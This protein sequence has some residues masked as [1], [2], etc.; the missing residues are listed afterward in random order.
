MRGCDDTVEI[1]AGH[2]DLD[3]SLVADDGGYAVKVLSEQNALR[4]VAN[5]KSVPT[6]AAP[7]TA[8]TPT[9]AK[10][11]AAEAAHVPE[12]VAMLR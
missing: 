8:A 6:R 11:A 4:L 7:T 5:G 12:Q 2:M 1:V 3:L 10:P 9:P